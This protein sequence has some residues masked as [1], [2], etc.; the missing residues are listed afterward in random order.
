MFVIFGAAAYG[1][2]N[3]PGEWLL[4]LKSGGVPWEKKFKVELNQA[5][6]LS[7][8]EED[9]NK[10]PNNPV[11]K[12]T[13][14]LTSKDVQEIHQ[15]ALSVLLEPVSNLP[16]KDEIVD[17]TVINLELV[18]PGRSLARGYHLGLIQEEAPALAKLLELINKYVPKEHQIF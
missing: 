7:V 18:T 12:L 13:I 9:P 1:Q 14:K 11:T 6:L 17:G 2:S 8:V 15:Q 16:K 5:G 3:Q 10:I 4:S